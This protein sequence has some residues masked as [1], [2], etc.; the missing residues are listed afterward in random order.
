MDSEIEI[1]TEDCE[2]DPL[3]LSDIDLKYGKYYEIFKKKY[4]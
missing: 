4:F 2:E 3:S 1:K